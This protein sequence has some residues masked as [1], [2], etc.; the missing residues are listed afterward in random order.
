MSGL[1]HYQPFWC[2]ENIWHLAADPTPGSGSRRVLLV[3]GAGGNVACW[4]QRAADDPLAPVL[5]DYHVVLLV[6]DAVWDLDT[7]LGC[8]LPSARWLAETFPY[9]DRIPAEFR[10][11]FALVEATAYRSDF[12]TDRAHMRTRDGR[13]RHPPP[14]WP[15]PAAPD[16]TTLAG[17]LAQATLDLDGLRTRLI[18]AG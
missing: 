18:R 6:D 4:H 2:E 8:P 12:T 13:W 10:P 5:W 15:P 14:P 3:T 1:P 11:R 17:Y 16:G 7:T 9:Q